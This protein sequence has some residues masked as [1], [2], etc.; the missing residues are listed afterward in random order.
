MRATRAAVLSDIEA[1]Y[2]ARFQAFLF[3]ATAFLDDPESAWDVVQESFASAV[4]S[5]SSYAGRGTVEAWLWKIAVNS[6]RDAARRRARDLG[7]GA[8]LQSVYAAA[9]ADPA[10]PDDGLRAALAALPER[11]RLA[12]FLRYY[13]DL[14]YQTIASSLGASEGTVAASL[15][16]GRAALRSRLTKEVLS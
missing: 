14:D 6:M 12:I 4:Q 10:G 16:A 13:G 1:V 7:L 8:K 15:N 11:Q 5:A 3:T 2:R 9:N